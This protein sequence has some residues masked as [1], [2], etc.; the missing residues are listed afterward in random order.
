MLYIHIPFCEKKCGYCSFNSFVDKR[1]QKNYLSALKTQ[2]RQELEHCPPLHTVYIGGGTPSSVDGFAYE[3]LFSII[4]NHSKEIQEITIEANPTSASLPW[5]K[6]MRGFGVNRLSL[7]V[8]SFDDKKLKLLTRSHT[9]LEA[10]TSFLHAREVGFENISI[11]IIYDTALDSHKIL[12]KELQGIQ[13]LS[14]EHL[15]AYS[16]IIEKSSGFKNEFQKKQD[17]ESLQKRYVQAF[18]TLLAQYEIANFGKKSLHNSGY[19]AYKEYVGVGA[20]AVGR[21]GQERIYPPKDLTSYIKNPLQKCKEK[22]TQEDIKFEKI[23]LGLRCDEG[24][25]L[26]ILSQYELQRV[27]MLEKEGTI[28]IQEQKVYNRDYFLAD[29]IALFIME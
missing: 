5:L 28:K 21:V 19:W 27:A 29:E 7:G 25:S 1:L 15:S 24:V 26:E 11:D 14:P 13:D 8:Q 6:T 12:E 23:F 20:G 17:N 2:L 22:L 9:A 4:H 16:L 10:R 3:D 18:D